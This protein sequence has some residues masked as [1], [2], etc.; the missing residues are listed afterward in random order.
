MDHR[1]CLSRAVMFGV[2]RKWLSLALAGGW[3]LLAGCGSDDDEGEP[4]DDAGEP[5]DSAVGQGADASECGPENH[6]ML[7]ATGCECE[8]KHDWVSEADDDFRCEKV[9]TSCGAHNNSFF[10]DS[11]ACDCVLGYSWVGEDATDFRCVPSET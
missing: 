3:L 4:G 8:P 5:A 1:G 6:S 11:G 9:D 10:T 7:T 2:Y